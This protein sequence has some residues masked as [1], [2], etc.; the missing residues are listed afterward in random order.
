[1]DRRPG[2]R[3][4]RVSSDFAHPLHLPA[5]NHFGRITLTT[6]MIAGALS[7]GGPAWAQGVD[8][9]VEKAKDGSELNI[10]AGAPDKGASITIERDADE[11]GSVKIKEKSEP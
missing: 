1:M 4:G 3:P 10:D 7:G 8:I 2:G 5:V 6:V 11:G 9:E